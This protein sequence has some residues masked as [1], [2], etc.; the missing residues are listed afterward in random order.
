MNDA[1]YLA[2][3]T[4]GTKTLARI[5]RADGA[6]LGRLRIATTTPE[7]ARDAIVAFV[8]QALPAGATLTGAGLAAFGPLVLDRQSPDLGRLLATPKP[9]WADANLRAALSGALGVAVTVDSDVN[10]AA[11][12]EQALGAGKGCGTLAYVTVGTGI[13]GGLAMAGR[14]LAGFANPEIGHAPIVR[15]AG[16][17]APSQCPFHDSCAEGLAAGPAIAARIGPGGR[18]GEHPA[19]LETIGDYLGQ[20]AAT[21]TLAWSPDRIV[22]GGGVLS[23]PGLVGRIGSAMQRR[24]GGYD[25][26]WRSAAPDYCVSA[27]L[28]DAGLEGAML[29]ARAPA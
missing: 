26:G 2:I 22:W 16:D 12:A 14:T 5:E 18:L 28:D 13:G 21:I 6:P 3:E 19:L 23:T 4:G 10:A 20:L 17:H 27:M 25:R 8:E 24:L 15:A 1:Y 9:G 29:M 11:L 7:A